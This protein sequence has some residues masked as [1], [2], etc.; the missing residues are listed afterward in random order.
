M[1]SGVGSP[2][3]LS[4]SF[5]SEPAL[6]PMR[7]GM[8]LS[9]A[10]RVTSSTFQRAPMFPGLMRSPVTPFSMTRIAQR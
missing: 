10:I 4:K 7:I 6:T 9:A 1:A 8:P 2:N 5:S 3:F